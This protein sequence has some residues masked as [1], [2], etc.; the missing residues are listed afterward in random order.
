MAEHNLES[1]LADQVEGWGRSVACEPDLLKHPRY[2][3]RKLGST[4]SMRPDSWPS[5][6]SFGFHTVQH[7]L[8]SLSHLAWLE[9]Y[10]GKVSA[11]PSSLSGSSARKTR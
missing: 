3:P 11:F 4:G 1:H 9:P 6:I 8:A 10:I 2:H 7:N 5:V